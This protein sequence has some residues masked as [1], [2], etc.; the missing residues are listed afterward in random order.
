MVDDDSKIII[1][2]MICSLEEPIEEWSSSGNAWQNYF[3]FRDLRN[4]NHNSN[5]IAGV[6]RAHPKI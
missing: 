2:V 5:A 4:R 1:D 3:R 6:V